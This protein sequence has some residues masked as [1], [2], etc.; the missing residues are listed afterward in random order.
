M[1]NC[2][3]VAMV[4]KPVAVKSKATTSG[5]V[6]L[7]AGPLEKLYS[8]WVCAGRVAG[9]RINRKS[10]SSL[11]LGKNHFP[12]FLNIESRFKAGQRLN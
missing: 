10:R 2:G 9:S 4:V 8:R 11:I 6:K 3:E 5:L 7:T 12:N 1:V